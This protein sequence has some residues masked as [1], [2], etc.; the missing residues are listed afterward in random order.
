MTKRMSSSYEQA[1][2]FVTKDGSIIRELM[3]PNIHGNRGQSLAEAIVPAESDTAAHRH[4]HSE[5]IYHITAGSGLMR[6]GDVEFAVAIGDTICIPAGVPHS[7]SNPGQGELRLLCC[8]SPPYAD[9]DT[10]LIDSGVENGR[11]R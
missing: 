5:E 4:H 2:P 1:T 8:S 6:L 10:E 3:H 11:L 7:L 9:D